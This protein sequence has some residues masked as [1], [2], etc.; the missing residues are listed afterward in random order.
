MLSETHQTITVFLNQLQFVRSGMNAG[1]IAA[2]YMVMT[3]S[4]LL[5]GASARVTE[6]F[7]VQNGNGIISDLQ[8]R[9]L[10]SGFNMPDGTVNCSRFDTAHQP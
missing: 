8:H 5:G 7:G 2:V 9:V 6:R 10:Y 3:L 4:G 1:M